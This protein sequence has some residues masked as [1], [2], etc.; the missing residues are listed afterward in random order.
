[1]RR[2]HA[3]IPRE[4][5]R[6]KH[7]RKRPGAGAGQRTAN[8]VMRAFR[9]V[10]NRALR[11]HPELPVNPILNVD[12]NKEHRRTS[13]IPDAGLKD[14]HARV[15]ALT[16]AVRRDYLLFTLFSGLR[17]TNAAEPR[18]EQVDWERR[19][20]HVP[21]P[22]SQQPFDLPLS[23]FL[24]DLLKARL[25]GNKVLAPD[26]PWVFPAGHGN[27]H[28][29][30]TRLEGGAARKANAAAKDSGAA[31]RYTPH[32]LRRTFISVAESLGISREARQLLVNHAT[33]KTDVH[34]GYVIP[35]LDALRA[36]MQAIAARL[37]ALCAPPAATTV[38]PLRKRAKEAR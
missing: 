2:R 36:H 34:G 20:L 7:G 4:I 14:W 37:H 28:I 33:P 12:W 11:E 15:T 8:H 18:W 23:D 3:E 35:E 31:P 9:A 26:S 19:A 13:R 27:G 24:L 29:V 30:E 10:Y 17:R 6:G 1:V 16:N 38:V 21:K 32:D 5:A 22:K 25:E